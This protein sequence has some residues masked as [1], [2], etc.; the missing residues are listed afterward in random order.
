MTSLLKSSDLQGIHLV[1]LQDARLGTVREVFIDPV[2]GR[3]EFLIV[4]AGGLLGGSG[5]FHPVPWAAVRFDPIRK[6]FQAEIS[7]DAF[8]A[9][10]S[11]DRDQLGSEGYG[12]SDQANRHFGAQTTIVAD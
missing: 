4:D 3:A 2:I 1:G 10:P 12:W 7:K 11:Y 5:K 8:K 9:G 6:V